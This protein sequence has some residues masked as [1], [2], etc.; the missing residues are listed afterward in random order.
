ML[1]T[2]HVTKVYKNLPVLFP[3]DFNGFGGIMTLFWNQ[4]LTS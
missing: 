1:S 3:Y 4:D 2:Y